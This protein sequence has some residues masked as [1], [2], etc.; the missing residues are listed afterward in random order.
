MVL[1]VL[2]HKPSGFMKFSFSS[3]HWLQI[4]V[5]YRRIGRVPASLPDMQELRVHLYVTMELLCKCQPI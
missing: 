4:Q 5:C 3:T 1:R 2:S